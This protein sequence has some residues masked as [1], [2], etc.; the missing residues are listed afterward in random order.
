MLQTI[1]FLFTRC[2]WQLPR[3][4]NHGSLFLPLMAQRDGDPGDSDG[5]ERDR[6]DPAPIATREADLVVEH[7]AGRGT[8]FSPSMVMSSQVPGGNLLSNRKGSLNFFAARTEPVYLP[9]ELGPV[10]KHPAN[11]FAK[12]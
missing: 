6:H 1:F 5:V 7:G 3:S 9:A 11:T 2:P 10:N 12:H 4:A 8:S